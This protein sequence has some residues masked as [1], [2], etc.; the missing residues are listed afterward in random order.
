MMDWAP[1]TESFVTIPGIVEIRYSSDDPD[2][3]C[4]LEP[5]D[6]LYEQSYGL[7][8][9]YGKKDKQTKVQAYFTCLVCECD[10]KSVVTLRAHCRGQKHKRRALQKEMDFRKKKAVAES[11]KVST[12][13]MN[14]RKRDDRDDVRVRG[15]NRDRSRS[16]LRSKQEFYQHDD[17]SEREIGRERPTTSRR[18]KNEDEDDIIEVSRTGNFENWSTANIKTTRNDHGSNDHRSPL[19]TVTDS[20][21]EAIDR[22]HRRVANL[23]MENINKYYPGT[24]DFD[25]ALHKLRDEDDY[26]RT[27]RKLSHNI[28]SKI[29][30]SYEAYNGTLEGISLTGDHKA[31]IKSQVERHFDQIPAIKI[32]HNNNETLDENY[33]K[34]VTIEDKAINLEKKFAEIDINNIRQKLDCSWLHLSEEGLRESQKQAN[35]LNE[36]MQRLLESLD[37]VIPL[38]DQHGNIHKF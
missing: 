32:C 16:P 5:I 11:D 28:R 25:P 26:S 13:H 34:L 7:P 12:F 2:Y 24:D 3:D 10:L 8:D 22:L 4:Y 6:L 37:G 38:A 30:D 31:F 29:K 18:V 20:T 14:N 17:R 23:V 21:L 19:E 36:K 33:K 1:P 9:T 15:I 35:I 27:A